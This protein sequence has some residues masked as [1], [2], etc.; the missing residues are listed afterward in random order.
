MGMPANLPIWKARSQR[1]RFF[2]ESQ[3]FYIRLIK[4]ER[5]LLLEIDA[6][7]VGKAFTAGGHPTSLR[8]I[9]RMRGVSSSYNRKKFVISPEHKAL[10]ELAWT[11]NDHD[12]SHPRWFHHSSNIVEQNSLYVQFR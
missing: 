12:T 2:T 4:N 6:K 10:G 11:G 5:L 3:I 9:A 7:T 8:M 1:G